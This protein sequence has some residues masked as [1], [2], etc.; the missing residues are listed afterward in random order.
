MVRHLSGLSATQL[1]ELAASLG[2]KPFRGKQLFD[3][4]HQRNAT[5]LDAIAV[6]PA[7]FRQK[8]LDD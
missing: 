5:Q 4:L 1:Q 8:L 2:E 7:S 3:H 6:L